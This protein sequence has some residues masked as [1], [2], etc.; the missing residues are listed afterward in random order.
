MDQKFRCP[1][2]KKCGGCQ[3]DITYAQQL[4]YKQRTVTSLLG[5]FHR[6]EPI[7]PIMNRIMHGVFVIL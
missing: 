6:V 5:K 1:V 7:R 2:Y 4:S 3:L